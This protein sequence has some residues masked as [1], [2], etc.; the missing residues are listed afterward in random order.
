MTTGAINTYAWRKLRDQVVAEEPTCRLAFPDL[1]TGTSQTAD[2]ILTRHE[3][4]DLAMT[5]S[6]LRGA[7]HPCNNARSNTPDSAL[8]LDDH[9]GAL[10]FFQ[11]DHD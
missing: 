1:C 10:T 4:P 5:R 7:C 2:H 6:N 8:R 11:T 9:G 3:R